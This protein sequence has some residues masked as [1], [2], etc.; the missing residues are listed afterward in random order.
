MTGMGS[1]GAKGML[2]MKHSGAYTIAQEEETSADV[3]MPHEAIK[4][5]AV[6]NVLPLQKIAYEIIRESCRHI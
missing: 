2:E 4:G 1:D 6:D 3:G 5:G